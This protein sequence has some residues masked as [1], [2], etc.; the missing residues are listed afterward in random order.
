ML[1]MH[2][3]ALNLSYNY[4]MLNVK[5]ISIIIIMLMGWLSVIAMILFINSVLY[6]YVVLLD[7]NIIVTWM[8]K[9]NI[10]TVLLEYLNQ[11]CF[12]YVIIMMALYTLCFQ[13]LFT[14]KKLCWHNR[15]GPYGNSNSLFPSAIRIWSRFIATIHV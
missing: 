2:C 14:L 3:S 13:L 8:P 4:D 10:V 11:I 5:F 1:Y 9:L 7:Y 12:L 6:T 15:Q